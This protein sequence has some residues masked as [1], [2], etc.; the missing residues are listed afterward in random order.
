MLA[1]PRHAGG[2]VTFF[3][4]RK[5]AVRVK[6]CSAGARD[7]ATVVNANRSRPAVTSPQACVPDAQPN[8]VKYAQFLF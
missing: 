6:P 8:T 4:T 7:L 3:M 5:E 2:A 1:L